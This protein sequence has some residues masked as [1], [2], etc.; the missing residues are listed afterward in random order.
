MS[1]PHAP[2]LGSGRGRG[3]GKKK[4]ERHCIFILTYDGGLC[5]SQK[6]ARERAAGGTL[7]IFTWTWKES[8][9]LPLPLSRVYFNQQPL[10]HPPC[11]CVCGYTHHSWDWLGW[12]SPLTQYSFEEGLTERKRKR[13]HTRQRFQAMEW[14][15]QGRGAAPEARERV[16]GP[17]L[18]FKNS[19]IWGEGGD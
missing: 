9:T 3:W 1:Q 7:F 6:K 12:P 5:P 2:K 8:V 10:L 16:E 17:Q 4:E 19:I 13:S 18:L 15:K 11:V 14:R